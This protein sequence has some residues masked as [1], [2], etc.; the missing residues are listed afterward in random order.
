MTYH[1]TTVEEQVEQARREQREERKVCPALVIVH[2]VYVL[3][4]DVMW[5][6]EEGGNG[7]R[8]GWHLAPEGEVVNGLGVVEQ[9]DRY[10]INNMHFLKGDFCPEYFL[11]EAQKSE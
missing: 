6:W 2:R 11:V 1:Q 8:K 5:G 9:E 3:P 4:G 7:W 10:V